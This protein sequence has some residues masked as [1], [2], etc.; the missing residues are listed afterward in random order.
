MLFVTEIIE[1]TAYEVP[2]WYWRCT[3]GR[4]G[5]RS[6]DH[7]VVIQSARQHKKDAHNDTTN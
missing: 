3:C 4:I 5:K 6:R 1:V 7:D 2:R